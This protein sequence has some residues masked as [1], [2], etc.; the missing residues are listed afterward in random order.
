MAVAERAILLEGNPA[1]PSAEYYLHGVSIDRACEMRQVEGACL[2]FALKAQ[3]LLSQNPSFIMSSASDNWPVS[4]PIKRYIFMEE[5]MAEASRAVLNKYWIQ[6][7]RVT[8]EVETLAGL[9]LCLISAIQLVGVEKTKT[10]RDF[11]QKT[12]DA[13]AVLLG[14]FNRHYGVERRKVVKRVGGSDVQKFERSLDRLMII[15]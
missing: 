7:L 1:F 11:P 9:R 10:L 12:N 14:F 13:R 15:A 4:V 3:E 5:E 2:L 6:G 8:S